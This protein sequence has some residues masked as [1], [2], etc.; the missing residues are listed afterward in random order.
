MAIKH[1]YSLSIR[2]DSGGTVLAS[3]T[4]YTA[5]AEQNFADLAPAGDHLEIDLEI[6]VANIKSFF[7]VSDKD[8]RFDTNAIGHA[9]GET[10]DLVAKKP[11]WWNTDQEGDNPLT[12]D[13]TT[14]LFF[15]N[16][17][18]LDANVKG[19]FLVDETP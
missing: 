8:V 9:G 15:V 4:E 19:G 6:T 7:I 17:G 10:F 13:I 14:G 16:D 18:A 1:T 2:N 5:S 3:T 11:L 12:I